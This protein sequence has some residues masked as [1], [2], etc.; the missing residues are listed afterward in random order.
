MKVF[1]IAGRPALE[2]KYQGMG[3][4]LAAVVGGEIVDFKYLREA[5]LDFEGDYTEEGDGWA[6]AAQAI[7][8]PRLGPTVR[9]LQAIGEVF[10]GMCSCYEFVVL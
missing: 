10:V 5:L 9:H 3:Y 6:L 2:A 1:K 8:D 4:A 7:H